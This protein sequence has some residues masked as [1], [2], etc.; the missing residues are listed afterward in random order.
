LTLEEKQAIV[1]DK[2]VFWTTS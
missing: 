1:W 2:G